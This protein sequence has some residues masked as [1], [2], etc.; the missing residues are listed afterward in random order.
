MARVTWTSSLVGFSPSLF[1][2]LPSSLVLT[3]PPLSAR[4]LNASMIKM[5]LIIVMIIV[6]ILPFMTKV[7]MT[8]TMMIRNPV[9]IANQCDR[10]AG[11]L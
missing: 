6:M 8:K 4:E 9:T 3:T 2:R 5:T 7:M 10:K 11:R 1:I